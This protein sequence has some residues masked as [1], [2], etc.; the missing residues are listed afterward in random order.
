MKVLPATVKPYKQTTVFDENTVPAGL[1]KSH[2]TREGVWAKI[3][4]LEGELIYRILDP[5]VEEIK[6]TP[7]RF[8]VVEPTVKHEVVPGDRVRFYVEFYQ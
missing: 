3:I 2:S 4:V 1:R 6:L 7:E 8:G 5:V